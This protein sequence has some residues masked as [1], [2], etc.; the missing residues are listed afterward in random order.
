MGK[1]RGLLC[2]VLMACGSPATSPPDGGTDQPAPLPA[3]ADHGWVVTSLD[4]RGAAR[5]LWATSPVAGSPLAHLQRTASAYAIPPDALATL[6]VARTVALRSGATV[7]TFRQQVG[8]VEVYGSQT[9]VL[10]RGDGSLVAIA[11]GPHPAATP[12]LAFA[13]PLTAAQAVAAA[14][15]AVTGADGL[16]TDRHVASGAWA[17]F[18]LQHSSVVASEPI[19]ARR[20]LF[21]VRDKLRAA[22]AVELMLAPAGSTNV[23]G[24]LR[25]IA[26]DTGAVLEAVELTAADTY[27]Y[28]VYADTTLRPNND[29]FTDFAPHPTGVPDGSQPTPT[30]PSLVAMQSFNTAPGGAVDPWLPAGATETQGNNIDAYTD[31]FAPDGF[32]AGQ[33]FR[34]STT[35]LRTFDRVYDLNQSALANQ[36]QTMAAITHAF[37]VTNWLHDYYYDSGF[38]EKAA[39]AQQDNYGRGGVAGDRMLVEVQDSAD[40]QRDNANM[41]TPADG[42]SPRMQVFVW[43]P[44]ETRF[45]ALTPGGNQLAGPAQYG[46]QTFDVT[47]NVVLVVDSVAPTGDACDTIVNG[48]QLTG[49]VAL[50]DRGICN[51]IDKTRAAQAKGAIGVIIADNVVAASPPGLGGSGGQPVTIPTLSITKASGDALKASLAGGN[52]SARLFRSGGVLRDG[53]LDSTVVAH[54]WG[55]YLHHRFIGGCTNVQCNAISEGWGDFVSMHMMVRAGDNLAGTYALA[56]HAFAQIDNSWYFG[57][58]RAPYSTDKTK[59]PITFRNIGD[60]QPL[61]VGPP[62]NNNGGPNSEV[63]NA[64]EIWA[65]MMWEA[66]ARMLANPGARTFAQVQRDMADYVVTGLAL[67]PVDATYTEQ[68]DAILAAAAAASTAD[69]TQLA[70]G[71]AARG[72]GTCAVSPARTSTTLDGVVESFTLAPVAGVGTVTL[73]DSLVTCD[74]DGF[75]DAQER[76]NVSIQVTNVGATALADGQLSI[77]SSTAGV[78]FPSGTTKAVTS[79]SPMG[80]VIVKIPI[81]LAS[82]FPDQGTVQLAITVTS[83]AT[84]TPSVQKTV[85]LEANRDEVPNSSTTDTVES[86]VPAWTATGAGAA[87]VWARVAESATQHDWQGADLARQSDTSLVSP[88]LAVGA[89]TFTMAFRHHFQF[90]NSGGQNFD[91]GVLEVSTDNGATFVDASMFGTVPYNG[92]I[93]NVSGNPLGGRQGFVRTSAGFPAFVNATVN[94]G[95]ALANKTVLVRFRIG[96]DEAAG[97]L[98]WTI[99][100]IAFTGITNKPFRTVTNDTATCS[101]AKPP[102]SNAGPDQTVPVSTL[103]T[104][105]GSASSDPNGLPLTFLWTQL[106]GTPVTLSSRT[107]VKPTF[108][109]PAAAATLVFRLHVSNGT[110]AAND[111]V[112]INVVAGTPPDAG[113]PDAPPVDAA[114]DAATPD[115]APDAATPDAATPDA[116]TPDGA[117]PDAAVPDG[118]T[119]PD[120]SNPPPPPPP[121]TSDGGCCSTGG[122]SPARHA[123]LVFAVLVLLAR[124][125]RRV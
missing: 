7:T 105:D 44:Q 10:V 111:T 104:L 26:A 36:S 8:G 85:A 76:G 14:V 90:E 69:F 100:D 93:S 80:S 12:G 45:V 68:R 101:A 31:R 116:A 125:R 21:P 23:R 74:S 18:A 52:V 28:R 91:G 88:P 70:Q 117:V 72:A 51:F 30:T 62:Y 53:A 73:D 1:L 54:E 34:A 39:N 42:S 86:V 57:I 84:C 59:N 56:G 98:G 43:S 118:S 123:P 35:S 81:E 113:T 67:T 55:H 92:T 48:A 9:S 29:P 65:G 64:G 107:V 94:F 6:E 109:A 24:A 2:L 3:R 41:S 33:D 124:R 40:T 119:T 37:Y 96:T 103:V 108:T 106:S 60:S 49:K 63:H 38:D 5:F 77:S 20:V 75:L 50:I 89:G 22:Y 122:G 61:P 17:T 110:L 25:V 87:A 115:A 112:T 83:G 58:R 32:T 13:F 99:D 71:F 79:V 102:I 97:D 16:V 114:P 95:T 4:D 78:T 27:N 82:T 19:R 66:Y 120:A 11:G 121:P 47:G 46:P 15:R